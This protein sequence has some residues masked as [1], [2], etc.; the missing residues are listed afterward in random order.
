MK[1]T[2]ILAVTG[3]ETELYVSSD[4]SGCSISR[5]TDCSSREAF[6]LLLREW[7]LNTE[8]ETIGNQPN[9]GGADWI[10]ILIEDRRYYLNADAS[11]KG[12]E[13]YLEKID[14]DPSNQNKDN[15]G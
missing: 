3:Q 5:N 9:Y 10:D 2:P 13:K 7:Y 8:E 1:Y 6:E 12:I 11:R 4:E 15:R 14:T